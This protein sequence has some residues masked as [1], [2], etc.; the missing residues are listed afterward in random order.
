MGSTFNL[1]LSQRGVVVLPKALFDTYHLEAGDVLTLIDLGGVFV[2][3]PRALKIDT[4]ADSVVETLHESGE[5]LDSLL[6]ALR[7]LRENSGAA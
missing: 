4:L 7:Q 5:S 1:Q 2:L 6:A 3:S